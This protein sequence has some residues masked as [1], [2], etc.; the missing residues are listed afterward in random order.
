MFE[1]KHQGH[2]AEVFTK[3]KEINKKNIKKVFAH[4]FASFSQNTSVK[5][6]FSWVLWCAPRRS[7]VAHDLGPFSTSQK[8]VLFLSR[9]Q[10]IFENLQGLRPRPRIDLRDQGL[11]IVSSRTPPLLTVCFQY[12]N[13]QCVVASSRKTLKLL[14]VLWPGR[15]P[16]VVTR[17]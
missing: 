10:G 6:C 12:L 9:G 3:K 16:V 5:N 1:A 2:S 17:S 14:F 15:L 7:D 11:Q 8:T 4:K 13:W